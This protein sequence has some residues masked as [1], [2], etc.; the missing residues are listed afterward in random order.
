VI[1]LPTR[2]MVKPLQSLTK[3][4]LRDRGGVGVTNT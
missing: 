1:W 4:E 2:A 3:S